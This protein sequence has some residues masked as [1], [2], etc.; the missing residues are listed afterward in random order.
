MDKSLQPGEI[1]VLQDM[2]RKV[3]NG[4]IA[5]VTGRLKRRMLYDLRN[6]AVFLHLFRFFKN[7]RF[8]SSPHI[9]FLSEG[10]SVGRSHGDC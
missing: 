6:P 8:S 2:N 1:G 4:Q 10:E 9:Q 5:E 3:L 7:V